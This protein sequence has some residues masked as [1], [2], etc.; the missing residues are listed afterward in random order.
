MKEYKVTI[1][2]VA[3]TLQLSDEDA[4]AMGVAS[5]AAPEPKARTVS[6]KSRTPANKS[7]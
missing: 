3:T 6:H 4:E 5:A 7:D 2:G 1:N